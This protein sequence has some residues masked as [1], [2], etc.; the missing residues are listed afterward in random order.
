MRIVSGEKKGIIL[1]GPYVKNVRPAMDKIK[2]SIFSLV[3]LSQTQ[4]S[5]VLDVFAGTGSVGLEA[6]SRGASK[7]FFIEANR[8][9]SK[10]IKDNI[11]ILAYEEKSVVIN[12][13]FRIAIRTLFNNHKKFDMI[14]SDPPYNLGLVE[15]FLTTIEKYDILNVNGMLVMEIDRKELPKKP[16]KNLSVFKHKEYG[17]TNI[18]IFKKN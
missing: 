17:R 4:G 9:M 14:F 6:L 8:L 11:N 10:N 13:D 12:R 5:M 2:D 1:K 7:C 15:E 18:L 16:P 3:T